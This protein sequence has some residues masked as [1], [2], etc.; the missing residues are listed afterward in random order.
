MK[1]LDEIDQDKD[2]DE[3]EEFCGSDSLFCIKKSE[4]VDISDNKGT[5]LVPGTT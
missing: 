1:G 3:T 5:L 4:T 2:W